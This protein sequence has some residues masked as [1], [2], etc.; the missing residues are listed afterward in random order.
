MFMAIMIAV[1]VQ[2][3]AQTTN[4]VYNGSNYSVTIEEVVPVKGMTDEEIQQYYKELNNNNNNTE[5]V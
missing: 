5:E 2:A 1:V 4:N 3:N